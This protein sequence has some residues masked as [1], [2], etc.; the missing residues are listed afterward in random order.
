MQRGR[1]RRAWVRPPA[2]LGAEC[3]LLAVDSDGRLLA[4]EVKPLGGT[5]AWVPAQATMYARV[6]QKWIDV[7]RETAQAGFAPREVIEGMLAQ[8]QSLGQVVN[9][10]AA[11]TDDLRVTP[12]VVI[13]RGAAPAQ[14]DKMLR[15]RDAL[16]KTRPERPPR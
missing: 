2:T 7:D 14:K 9:F 1:R 16:A 13:Q 8:R 4:I 6:L 12:V 10:A 5:I 11:L 15:L 3:D